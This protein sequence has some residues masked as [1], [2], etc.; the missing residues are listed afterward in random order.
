MTTKE[1]YRNRWQKLVSK[2]DRLNAE[3]ENA[4]KALPNVTHDSKEFQKAFDGYYNKI[5]KPN[6]DKIDSMQREA[7]QCRIRSLDK[8]YCNCHLY[9]DIN[10]YEVIEVIS[11][12]SL[13]LRS[14]SSVQTAESVERLR[15]SFIPGGFCGNFDNLVQ[16]WICTPDRNGI[17]VTVHKRKDGHF[18]ETG[19]STPYVLSDKPKR[20]RDFN[21]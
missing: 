2:I 14:M 17:V 16:E 6:K 20:Y 1:Q 8:F 5:C 4:Y 11:D 21:F 9:S 10:P 12:N 13:K 15:E 3:S 18:Y 19:G 7:E